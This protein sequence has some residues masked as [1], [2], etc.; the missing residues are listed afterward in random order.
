MKRIGCY[1]ISF[2]VIVMLAVSAQGGVPLRIVTF[3]VMNMEEGSAYMPWTSRSTDICLKLH[4]IHADIIG[5]QDA[6]SLQVSDLAQGLPEY[7]VVAEKT[8]PVFKHKHTNPIMYNNKVLRLVDSGT[9][10]IA[11]PPDVPANSWESNHASTVCWAMFQHIKTGESFLI[12]NTLWDS[13]SMAYYQDAAILLKI[14]LSKMTNK[15]PVILM[16]NFGKSSENV[17]YPTILSR[18]FPMQD[19]WQAAKKRVGSATVNNLGNV[20]DVAEEMTDFVFSSM[21]FKVK[22]MTIVNTRLRDYYL[23][24]HNIL[25][26]EMVFQ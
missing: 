23:S 3:D 22:K 20:A 24:N 4:R 1:M 14:Q 13:I 19:C 9:F 25:L 21:D 11:D 6:D 15:T 5:L 12:S 26:G 16:G 8:S 18:V 7:S 2:A 17:F 10:Y